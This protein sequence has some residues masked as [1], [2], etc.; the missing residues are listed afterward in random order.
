MKRKHNSVLFLLL[1]ILSCEEPEGQSLQGALRAL[2][3]EEEGQVLSLEVLEEPGALKRL[4]KRPFSQRA[5]ELGGLRWRLE[6]HY[7]L[8][9]AGVLQ[10]SLKEQLITS[11]DEQGQFHLERLGQARSSE[12]PL[13]ESGRA[14]WWVQ[15]HYFSARLPGA[16]HQVP[17]QDQEARRC[18]D[19]ALEPLSGLLSLFRERL[20]WSLS[21]TT[22]ILGREIF[23]LSFSALNEEEPQGAFPP[24]DFARFADPELPHEA[25]FPSFVQL[26]EFKGELLLE[27]ETALPL[28]ARLEAQMRFRK[29]GREAKLEIVMSL[30]VEP[31]EGTLSP[32]ENPQVYAPRR[33]PYQ[34]DEQL[35]G[36]LE[37]IKLPEPGDAP[38]LRIGAGNG[39]TSR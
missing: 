27:R 31:W 29:L 9:S 11:L 19:T 33:R 5:S 32:P 38:P 16:S 22:Q 20:N 3:L 13:R 21:Q 26:R 23:K 14:C 25:L 18:L 2:H 35:V 10:S 24:A 8:S 6:T 1:L 30:K 4:L 7:Q 12:A 34:R 17:L 15:G 36:P 28:E 37:E 39:E